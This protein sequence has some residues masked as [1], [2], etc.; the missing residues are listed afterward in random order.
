VK[1]LIRA[2]ATFFGCGHF[3]IAPATFASFVFAALMFV[4]PLPSPAVW[5]ALTLAVTIVGIWAAG[6]A[7]EEFGHDGHP[8]VIDEIAGMLVTLFWMPKELWVW[9]AGFALFRVF[10]VWKPFPAG[11]AQA[12]PGG[13][14]VVMDD[15]LA[16]VYAHL[17]LRLAL[18]FFG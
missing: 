9:A 18:P 3:P 8:I 16:G 14:G 6:R 2:I 4:L 12:L 15:L 7:E 11:R 1:L 13:L 17:C 10:D 5:A